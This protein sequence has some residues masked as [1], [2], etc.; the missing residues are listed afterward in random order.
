MA[1][2]PHFTEDR[3]QIL[4][5]MEGGDLRSAL[6]GPMA[7]YN[8]WYVNGQIL[9]MDIVRGVFYL[10]GECPF[11]FLPPPI[12]FVYASASKVFRTGS[13]QQS[14]PFCGSRPHGDRY[15]PYGR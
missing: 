1:C 14:L 2:L 12:L 5:L 9:A 4:E 6:S 13:I 8:N 3:L 11:L 7:E 15:H 10:H